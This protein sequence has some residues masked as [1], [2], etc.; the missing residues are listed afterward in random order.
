MKH[1]NTNILNL[2]E[3]I[4]QLPDDAV[5]IWEFYRKNTKNAL[6]I[7]RWFIETLCLLGARP[8][9]GN[10]AGTNSDYDW[11]PLLEFGTDP[12]QIAI[13]ITNQILDVSEN[14]PDELEK[15]LYGIWFAIPE[16]YEFTDNPTLC[17]KYTELQRN[18]SNQTIEEVIIKNVEKFVEGIYED[19]E[20]VKILYHTITLNEI[21]STNDDTFYK[22]PSDTENFMY[23]NLIVILQM[24]DVINKQ[25]G[26]WVKDT[27]FGD[28][29]EDIT[30]NIIKKWKISGR[31]PEINFAF[32]QFYTML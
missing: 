22:T 2:Y 19:D 32:P 25:S 24:A 28:T 3:L 8:V 11:I 13:N 12:K 17:K 18:I 10:A 23:R 21:F 27:S 30:K 6:D 26:K 15:V 4:M 31:I 16:L 9:R 14:M 7:C 1:D 29:P 5:G 20:L